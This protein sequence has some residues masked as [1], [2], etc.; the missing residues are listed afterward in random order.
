M[1][2][3][4]NF[5]FVLMVVSMLPFALVGFVCGA[6]TGAFRAGVRIAQSFFDWTCS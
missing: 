3:L 4:K 6:I 2:L 1:M 5:F